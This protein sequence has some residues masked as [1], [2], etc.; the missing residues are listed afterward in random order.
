M[1][2]DIVKTI[3]TTPVRINGQ[4]ISLQENKIVFTE[5]KKKL[6]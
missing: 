1:T 3:N 4:W 2:N 6:N 5:K